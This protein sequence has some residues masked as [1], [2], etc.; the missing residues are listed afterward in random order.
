LNSSKNNKT[1]FSLDAKLLIYK[2]L[3]YK[4]AANVEQGAMVN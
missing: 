1:T 2:T 3:H 4:V